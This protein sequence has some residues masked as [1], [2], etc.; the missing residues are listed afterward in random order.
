M[1]GRRDNRYITSPEL[2]QVA[3]LSC[4]AHLEFFHQCICRKFRKNFAC[5]NLFSSHVSQFFLELVEINFSTN[6]ILYSP[7]STFL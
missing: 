2:A 4:F 6:K 5:L 3:F 7:Y 1:L